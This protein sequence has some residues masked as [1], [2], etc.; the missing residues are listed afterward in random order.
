[1]TTYKRLTVKECA[2]A[3][4]KAENVAVMIHVRPDGDAV[5]SA[6][7]LCNILKQLG[8]DAK[9]LSSDKI[10]DRLQFILDYTETELTD[11]ADGRTAIAID[12]ASPAQLGTLWDGERAPVLMIDHHAVGEQFA[13]G[14]IIPEASSAAEVLFDVALTLQDEGKIK[15]T[16]KLSYALYCAM[17]SDT[18][19]FSYSNTGPK[20]HRYAAM[21]L[22]GGVDAADINHRLFNSKTKEQITAEGF[23]ASRL[24][25][26]SGG[27]ISYATVTIADRE[28]LGLLEEHFDTAIDVVRSRQGTKIAF[29]I[30]EID[31]GKF[32]VSLRSTEL[33]VASVAAK[34]GGG[35]HLRAAGCTVFADTADEVKT[36]ILPL[37]K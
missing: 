27:K 16:K 37:L 1:M 17:S 7:A 8:K 9:I 23:V 21:L 2:D 14:Y 28:R 20:T 11:N 19:C 35:G 33:D 26:A 5:G 31:K 24:E 36:I 25:S 18:G 4:C 15:L 10:P 12:V 34:F 6:A 3:L 13:N 22:E 29:V 32:K 30:K